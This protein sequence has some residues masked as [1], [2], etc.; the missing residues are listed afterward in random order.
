MCV[1]FCCESDKVDLED[2]KACQV[3]EIGVAAGRQGSIQVEEDCL[4]EVMN[5]C[6]VVSGL[7]QVVRS[8]RRHFICSAV[9]TRH[10][11]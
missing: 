6:L 8:S 4:K 11:F 9:K 7:T 5:D 1:M 2:F 3:N 10:L